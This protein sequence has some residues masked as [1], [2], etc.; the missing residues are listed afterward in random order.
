MMAGAGARD[1][2]TTAGRA[3]SCHPGVDASLQDDLPKVLD[4]VPDGYS[5]YSSSFGQG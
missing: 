4:G 2:A 5:D 3:G 1:H